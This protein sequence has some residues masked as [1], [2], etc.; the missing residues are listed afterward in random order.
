MR[1]GRRGEK[2]KNPSGSEYSWRRGGGGRRGDIIIRGC[3]RGIRKRGIAQKKRS[4][5]PGELAGGV[6]QV[7][8][9]VKAQ[10][11]LNRKSNVERDPCPYFSL[12]DLN[13]RGEG[14]GGCGGPV[15]GSRGG[16][17]RRGFNLF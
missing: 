4:K 1:G 16:E 12:F 8:G 10:R 7:V 5:A 17:G 14:G 6:R 3:Q 13:V 11:F 2:S 9:R 15:R